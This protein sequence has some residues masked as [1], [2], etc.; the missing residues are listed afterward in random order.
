MKHN[1]KSYETM[2]P[3]SRTF[4][5]IVFY[6]ECCK[7]GRKKLREGVGWE[8]TL[9]QGGYR[10]IPDTCHVEKSMKSAAQDNQ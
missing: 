2:L 4:S 10:S 8:A 6:Y 5:S 7:S 9:N 3:L 1:I